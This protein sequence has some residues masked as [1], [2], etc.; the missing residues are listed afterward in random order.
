[1][2][3]RP[4]AHQRLPPEVEALL[5]YAVRWREVK[6]QQQRGSVRQCADQ[7]PHTRYVGRLGLVDDGYSRLTRRARWL[8]TGL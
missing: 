5:D 6:D 4:V 1:M 8:A 7:S 3:A 2:K